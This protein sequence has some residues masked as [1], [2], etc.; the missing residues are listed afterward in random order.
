VG[1]GAQLPSK[2]E[3]H[4]IR[5]ILEISA[6]IPVSLRFPVSVLKG[7]RPSSNRPGEQGQK[8]NQSNDVDNI[9]GKVVSVDGAPS[10]MD[11]VT[12]GGE[13]LIKG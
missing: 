2:G 8:M 4:E 6:C 9:L 10:S 5:L 7:T 11:G 13:G 12:W 1:L 3:N